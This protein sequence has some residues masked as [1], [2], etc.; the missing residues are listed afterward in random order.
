MICF[1]SNYFCYWRSSIFY[2]F[3]PI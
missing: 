2:S 3:W 1:L